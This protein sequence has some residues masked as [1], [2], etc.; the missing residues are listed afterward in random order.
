MIFILDKVCQIIRISLQ[1]NALESQGSLLGKYKLSD[2]VND[3]KTW[4]SST[5][6]IWFDSGKKAWLIGNKENKGS[7]IAGVYAKRM[8]GAGPDDGEIIW[9]YLIKTMEIG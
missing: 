7:N 6:A 8:S 4:E 3:E 9:N 1:N 2:E 5:K